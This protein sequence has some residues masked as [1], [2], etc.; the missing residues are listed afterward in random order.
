[1]ITEAIEIMM[2]AE[3]TP[4]MLMSKLNPAARALNTEPIVEYAITD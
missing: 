2:N 1:M 4:T 3:P